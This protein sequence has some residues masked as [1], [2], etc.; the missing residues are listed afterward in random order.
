MAELSQ[1]IVLTKRSRLIISA[2]V[3]ITAQVGIDDITTV[4]TQGL[5]ILVVNDDQIESITASAGVGLTNTA[6]I[7]NFTIDKDPGT[8]RLEFKVANGGG[9]PKTRA[10]A[11]YSSVM[12]IP[13]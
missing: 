13:L 4:G 3:L 5:F 8:Y 7:C 12:V 6:T 9:S 10:V 2:T 1:T 11:R